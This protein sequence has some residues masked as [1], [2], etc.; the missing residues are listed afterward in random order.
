M[1]IPTTELIYFF[2]LSLPPF[3]LINPFKFVMIDFSESLFYSQLE[4]I[5]TIFYNS[6]CRKH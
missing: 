6:N 3:S 4:F 1:P 2:P 5:F